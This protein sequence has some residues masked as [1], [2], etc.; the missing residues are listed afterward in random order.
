MRKTKMNEVE[1]TQEQIK[2]LVEKNI[3]E[4]EQASPEQL[5]Q[6]VVQI[7]Y[8]QTIIAE[9]KIEAA[10]LGITL[11]EWMKLN[12]KVYNYENN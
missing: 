10:E 7:E 11:E 9:A 4:A 3:A 12:L 6:W 8:I 2:Q 5:H 1:L